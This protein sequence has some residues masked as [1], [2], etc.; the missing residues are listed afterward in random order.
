MVKPFVEIYY[1]IHK[2]IAILHEDRVGDWWIHVHM[3]MI[4]ESRDV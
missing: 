2:G 4:C 3:C 1:Q